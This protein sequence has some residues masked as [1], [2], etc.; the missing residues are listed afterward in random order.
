MQRWCAAVTARTSTVTLPA[1]SSS[2]TSARTP[3][4][5]SANWST[6]EPLQIVQSTTIFPVHTTHGCTFCRSS[7]CFPAFSAN[8]IRPTPPPTPTSSAAP[9]M[10]VFM[11][12]SIRTLA[13]PA[14]PNAGRAGR[15]GITWSAWA[16]GRI[17]EDTISIEDF[18]VVR[19]PRTSSNFSSLGIPFVSWGLPARAS[20]HVFGRPGVALHG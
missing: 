16:A 3:A 17:A 12:S 1:D 15:P 5:R 6:P 13:R 9:P 19:I 4:T 20:V 7:F 11:V 14:T 2:P 8:A 10:T 18:T